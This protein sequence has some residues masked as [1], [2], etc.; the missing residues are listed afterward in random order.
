MSGSPRANRRRAI[1]SGGLL[2]VMVVFI[3]IALQR[4]W[5][6]VRHDLAKMGPGTLTISLVTGIAALCASGLVW[7][8]LLASMGHRL[9]L[10]DAAT[11]FFSGQLGKYVPGAVWPAVIQNELGRSRSIPRSTM[12]GSYLAAVASALGSGAI[13]G[14]LALTGDTSAGVPAVVLISTL[15][16]L[17]A[18]I[19]V[20]HPRGLMR[21]G[22]HLARRLGRRLPPIHVTSRASIEAVAGTFAIWICYGVHCWVIAYALGA[23]VADIVP[24]TGAFALA[25]LAG[26]LFVPVPGGAGVREGVLVLV[27]AGTIGKQAGLSVAVASRLL[28]LLGEIVLA[29]AAGVPH[30]VRWAMARR[31]ERRESVASTD[32]TRVGSKTS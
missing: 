6:A 15:A 13:V 5:T 11:V 16:G 9:A 32:G 23:N 7:R 24:I 26:L 3:V 20:L 22:G 30:S 17:V 8:R 31:R 27:L 14:L 12:T 28:L 21:I 4:N 19:V 10:R 18:A 25:F 2:A 1:L 29:L